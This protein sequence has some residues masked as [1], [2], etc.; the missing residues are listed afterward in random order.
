MFSI[1]APIDTNR[2]EQFKVTKRAYDTFPQIKEFIMPTRSYEAARR[3]FE[4]N[5][6]MANVRLI[7]YEHKLGFNPSKALNIGVREAQYDNIIITSPEVMPLTQVLEQLE[8]FVGQNVVCHVDDEDITKKVRTNLVSS[9]FRGDSPAMYFLAMFNKGDIEKI[10]GWDEDFMK[11]YAYE[12][13]DFGE[14][15]KRA[16]LPFTVNDQIRALHQYH[17]RSETIHGGMAVNAQKYHWNTDHGVTWCKNG[18]T[19]EKPSDM[20][21]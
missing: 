3:Y 6:M 19:S 15:W 20:V 1:I 7:P 5:S 10:N 16:G 18:L 4:D 11:G 8:G 14:R 21:K 13:N 17:P 2:F 9:N 12:D